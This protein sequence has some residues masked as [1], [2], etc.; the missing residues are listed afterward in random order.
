MMCIRSLAVFLSRSLKNVAALGSDSIR[1]MEN[2]SHKHLPGFSC[3]LV[4]LS[5]LQCHRRTKT[6]RKG[7]EKGTQTFSAEIVLARSLSAVLACAMRASR[8]AQGGRLSQEVAARRL[9]E[10]SLFPSLRSNPFPDTL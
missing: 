3:V 8:S 7:R 4:C 2:I 1:L 9:F 5:L 10:T 6:V